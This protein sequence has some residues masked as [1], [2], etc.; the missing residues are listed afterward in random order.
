MKRKLTISSEAL[1]DIQSAT[2]FY[3]KQLPGLG[4]R[5]AEQAY[6]FIRKIEKMPQAASISHNNV[7]YKVMDRF[8]FIVTYRFDDHVTFIARVFNTNQDV[9]S[10]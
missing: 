2:D 5:F 1:R 8:P 3:N 9:G 6:S 10:I 4:K 7:R